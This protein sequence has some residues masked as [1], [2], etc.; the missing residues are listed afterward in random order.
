MQKKLLYIILILGGVL[1]GCKK[2]VVTTK[3]VVRENKWLA[4]K[5]IDRYS[6][7]ILDVKAFDDRIN[8]SYPDG[9]MSLDANGNFDWQSQSNEYNRRGFKSD[10]FFIMYWKNWNGIDIVP[11]EGG[12]R[13][14]FPRKQDTLFNYLTFAPLGSLHSWLSVNESEKEFAAIYLDSATNMYMVIANMPDLNNPPYRVSNYRSFMLPPSTYASPVSIYSFH[15]SF[16]VTGNGVFR[17]YETDNTFKDL[18]SL[19]FGEYAGTMFS[20]N[21][22]L[23]AVITN[24][25][26]SSSD[27]GE[28][29]QPKYETTGG[30]GFG[31]FQYHPMGN[32]LL[33]STNDKLYHF[34][35]TSSEAKVQ[36]IVNE[37]LE[38][39]F[40]T[41]VGYFNDTVFV[42][43]RSGTF[44]RSFN[45]V[46]EYKEP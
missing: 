21:N 46:L 28:T 34:D 33:A 20:F 16:F 8:F 39:N 37:G 26:Y 19:G 9:M 7:Y 32:V 44:K 29:W 41:N 43:T 35:L 12:A 45:E 13:Y 11:F 3:E 5:R 22:E 1:F 31:A 36:E 4:E 24:K 27:Q 38:N 42:G 15:N 18:L 30:T 14:V 40:I 17:R 2:E 6:K 10:H 23:Y 25:L